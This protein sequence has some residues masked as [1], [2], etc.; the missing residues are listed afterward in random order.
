MTEEQFTVRMGYVDIIIEI[1]EYN[2]VRHGGTIHYT[3]DVNYVQ[4]LR[5]GLGKAIISIKDSPP[6]KSC[7]NCG[8]FHFQETSELPPECKDCGRK[9]HWKPKEEPNG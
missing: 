4:K 9:T 6:Q 3:G 7:W 2:G 8:H 1:H 5:D